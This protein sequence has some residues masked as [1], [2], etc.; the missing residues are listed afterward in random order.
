MTKISKPIYEI[1]GERVQSLE[2]F[3]DEISRQLIPDVFWGRNLDAFNDILRGGLGLSHPK[4]PQSATGRGPLEHGARGM[5]VS[6][7][8]NAS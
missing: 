7:E 6:L 2:A 5:R 1:D 8:S 4:L 3:Y